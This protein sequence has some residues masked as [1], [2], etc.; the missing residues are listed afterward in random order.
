MIKRH[1]G[2]VFVLLFTLLVFFP[3]FFYHFVGDDYIAITKI[4]TST[5]LKQVFQLDWA[6][7]FRPISWSPF[8]LGYSLVGLPLPPDPV[9]QSGQFLAAYHFLNITLHL[10]NVLLVYLI[11]SFI[12]KSGLYSALCALIFAVHPVNSEAICWLAAF[13]DIAFSFFCLLSLILFTKSYLDKKQ[14]T[15]RVYYL[16]SIFGFILA[17]CSKEAAMSLPF[18]IILA[19]L[20]LEQSKNT[21]QGHKRRLSWLGYFIIAALYLIIRKLVLV[22]IALPWQELIIKSPTQIFKS[23]YHLRDLFFPVGLDLLKRLLYHYSLLPLSIII[24][25][26]LGITFVYIIVSRSK[27]HPVLVFSLLWVVITLGLPVLG[28]FAPARRHL[29]FPLVGF[30]IFLV[31]FISLLQKKRFQVA[32]FS[33]FIILEIWTTLGRNHLFKF[34]GDVVQKELFELKRDIPEFKANSIIYLV[35]L[36]ATI[37]NT[38]VFSVNAGGMLKSIYKDKN[39]AVSYLSG[40][41]FTEKN[42]QDIQITFLDNV[43]FVQSMDTNLNEFIRLIADYPKDLNDGWFNMPD[44]NTKSKITKTDKFGNTAEVIFRLNPKAINGKRVYIIGQKDKKLQ[45]LKQW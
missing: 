45:V 8:L 20:F 37:K 28:N 27:R 10:A 29:Y 7:Y 42:I 36:P 30:S 41:T 22:K 39:L 18:L 43:T 9:W 34:A 17:L 1:I 24:A 14:A 40:I 38:P 31:G 4:A 13:G 21:L 16:G 33:L 6:Y 11:A 44:S 3:S 23:A 25:F 32:L 2:L 26:L 12:F 35:G 19:S 5:N 15:S